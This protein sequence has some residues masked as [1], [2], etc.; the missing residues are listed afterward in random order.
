MMVGTTAPLAYTMRD[1]GH[2]T[3]LDFR[4]RACSELIA[5]EGNFS[6]AYN[7]RGLAYGASGYYDLAI[8]DFDKAIEINPKYADAYA[9]RGGAYL[10]KR[11]YDRAIADLNKAIELD[12]KL[13]PAYYRRGNAHLAKGDQDRAIAEYTMAIFQ[14][15]P[16][17][18][19]GVSTLSAAVPCCRIATEHCSSAWTPGVLLISLI[20]AAIFASSGRSSGLT[21][22]MSV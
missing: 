11:D 15:F 9:N 7:N 10:G 20:F 17:T 21:F 18:L 1:C 13:S 19:I 16:T 2:A 8:T 4:I 3:D 12:P 14:L 5:R 6:W 22:S